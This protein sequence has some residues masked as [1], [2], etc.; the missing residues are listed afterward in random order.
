M[1]TNS[2][3]KGN[4]IS[5]KGITTYQYKVLFI[6]TGFTFPH[7]QSLNWIGQNLSCIF[8]SLLSGLFSFNNRFFNYKAIQLISAIPATDQIGYS[9]ITFGIVNK[10][11]S[12]QK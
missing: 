1:N 6:S 11:S 12:T 4:C 10:I 5:S 9:K 8:M 3:Q 2:T 7:H